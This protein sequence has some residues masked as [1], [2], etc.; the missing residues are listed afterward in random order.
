MV[1]GFDSNL[2]PSDY[3][4]HPITTRP[5][6]PPSRPDFLLRVQGQDLNREEQ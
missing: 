3:E 4:S 2:Q 5:G 1:L 6:L